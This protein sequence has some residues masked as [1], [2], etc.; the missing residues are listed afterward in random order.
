ML[1]N[2]K[3]ELESLQNIEK[4]TQKSKYFK[5]GKG[6]YGQGDVFLGLTNP[7]VHFLS[8]KYF[9]LISIHDLGIMIKDK[10]HEIRQAALNILV[11]KYKKAKDLKSK[12]ALVDFYLKNL[13]YVNNWDL[14][15]CST[16]Y[17]LGPYYYE[18]AEHNELKKLALSDH[19]WTE[20]IAIIA[21]LH[22]VRMRSFELPFEIIK[23]KLTHKHDLIHKANGWVLREI[24][25]KG[26]PDRVEE[27]IKENI[28]VIPRT[29]L[30]YA[31]EK[32]EDSKRKQILNFKK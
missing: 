32:M 22:Y 30:R 2:L 28:E 13:E 21:M 12:K 23:L 20:R 5:G 18:T 16:H 4:A 27:F 19:L 6:Q 1:Q 15:D 17:I 8:K 24:W 31:I 7:Q 11:L 9:N 26:Q 3:E 29:T 25:K 14:V 10:V